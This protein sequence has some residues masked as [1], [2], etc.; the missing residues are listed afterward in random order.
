MRGYIAQSSKNPRGN[1]AVFVS[2][3]EYRVKVIRTRHEGMLH[4]EKT[5]F[6]HAVAVVYVDVMGYGL[7]RLASGHLAPISPEL[8]AAEAEY[9]GLTAEKPEPLII[10]MDA[11]AYALNEPDRD[12]TGVHPGKVRRKS[13]TRAA[14]YLAEYMTDCGAQMGCTVP[15]V[16]HTRADKLAYR[17]DRKLH[18]SPQ[19]NDHRSPGGNRRRRR[20][21]PPGRAN[22]DPHRHG[23]PV[24]A[25][26]PL[27]WAGFV[28]TG[29]LLVTGFPALLPQ[30]RV[31]RAQ[32]REARAQ[33]RE[34][35]AY[36]RAVRARCP[37]PRPEPESRLDQRAVPASA[38]EHIE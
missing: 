38:R 24:T 29:A 19:R 35:R 2:P 33:L 14:V 10:G 9:L 1:V 27:T 3:S 7:L 13:D 25:A 6:W 34:A 17:C 11:N 23:A 18:H 8:R 15:T 22:H 37:E 21:G 32:L 36:S 26:H 16:G 30:L 5:P 28:V 20:L 31:V 12:V 4:D